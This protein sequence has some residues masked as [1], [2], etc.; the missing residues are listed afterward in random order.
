[1]KVWKRGQ[2]HSP[3]DSARGSN[4][5]R[6]RTDLRPESLSDNFLA[7]LQATNIARR[8]YLGL[9]NLAYPIRRNNKGHY[10]LLNFEATHENLMEMERNMRLNE[11]VLRFMTIRTEEIVSEPS[12]L[13][14][15]RD[16]RESRRQE[17]EQSMHPP[18]P[19]SADHDDGAKNANKDQDEAPLAAEEGKNE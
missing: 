8:E 6:S 16:E 14:R 9:R 5:N 12:V 17:R 11:D 10:V 13:A 3:T 1:H 18:R 19:H 15:H 4:S 7:I 2:T